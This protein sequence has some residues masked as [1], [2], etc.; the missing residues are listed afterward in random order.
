MTAKSTQ[1]ATAEFAAFH[2]RLEE[3]EDLLSGH[4]QQCKDHTKFMV[5]RKEESSRHAKD[6]DEKANELKETLAT[7]S[8]LVGEA[9]DER[10]D[11]RVLRK[12]DIEA[13]LQEMYAMHELQMKA[14]RSIRDVRVYFVIKERQHATQ[15]ALDLR[16]SS[17]VRLTESECSQG[18]GPPHT[19]RGTQVDCVVYESQ[20]G[21]T[22]DVATWH[23][24][25]YGYEQERRLRVGKDVNYRGSEN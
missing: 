5:S 4:I 10:R 17:R 3:L 14:P 11:P 22:N 16:Q 6:R 21:N 9:R 24:V 13:V 25:L 23:N 18:T 12:G 15:R 2:N 7:V 19:V 1:S 8:R 20:G